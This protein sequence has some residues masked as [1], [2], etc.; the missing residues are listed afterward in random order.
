MKNVQGESLDRIEAGA[1]ADEIEITPAMIEAGAVEV[2]SYSP[3]TGTAQE[4]AVDVFRAML[5]AARRPSNVG[6]Q[7]RGHPASSGAVP[8][9]TSNEGRST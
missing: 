3:E 4:A 7:K 9:R 1:P 6:S 5:R 8:V 2:A